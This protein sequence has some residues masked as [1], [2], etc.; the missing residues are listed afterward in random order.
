MSRLIPHQHRTYRNVPPPDN[1]FSTSCQIHW[2]SW[3]Q[4][5]RFLSRL[6]AREVMW[7]VIPDSGCE[8]AFGN[9]VKPALPSFPKHSI[10]VRAENNKQPAL[11]S[12][13]LTPLFTLLW[14]RPLLDGYI[15]IEMAGPSH[16]SH[17][18]AWF[19]P[20]LQ[21]SLLPPGVTGEACIALEGFW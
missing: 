7:P 10:R 18:T 16:V 14:F 6:W 1:P 19:W 3:G 9:P 12:L 21:M 17:H 2:L 11:G 20:A 15:F 13:G 8:M 4:I 5:L